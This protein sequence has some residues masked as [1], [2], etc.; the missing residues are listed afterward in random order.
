M[1]IARDNFANGWQIETSMKITSTLAVKLLASD[2]TFLSYPVK[3][4]LEITEYFLNG[5][6]SAVFHPLCGGPVI[7]KNPVFSYGK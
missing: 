7:V 1:K 6:I 4:R 5:K 3:G 2:N